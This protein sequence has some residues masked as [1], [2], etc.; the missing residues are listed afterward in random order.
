MGAVLRV[1]RL[2]PA[3]QSLNNKYDSNSIVRF[4]FLII[5]KIRNKELKK[6][7]KYFEKFLQCSKFAS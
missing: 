4:I 5:F 3:S 6:S 7:L 1:G 2:V